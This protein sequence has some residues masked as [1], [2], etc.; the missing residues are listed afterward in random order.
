MKL[1]ASSFCTALA[2]YCP[3][4][5]KVQKPGVKERAFMP[6]MALRGRQLAT[7]NLL[8]WHGKLTLAG[9][10]SRITILSL[11]GWAQL[12]T[13]LFK[14][15]CLGTDCSRLLKLGWQNNMLKGK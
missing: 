13:A 3:V 14:G 11:Q 4:D 12:R 5:R 10:R 1:K 8:S 6:D 7:S 2:A 9:G 15:V